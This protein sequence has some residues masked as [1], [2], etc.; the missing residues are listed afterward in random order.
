MYDDELT[1][2]RGSSQT[3]TGKQDVYTEPH[4]HLS[5]FHW[6]KYILPGGIFGYFR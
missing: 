6:L 2:Q 4:V 5:Q 3:K 1:V